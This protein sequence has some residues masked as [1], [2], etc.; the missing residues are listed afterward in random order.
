MPGSVAVLGASSLLAR[1]YVRQEA[2]ADTVELHLFVRDVDAMRGW[3]VQNGLAGRYRVAALDAFGSE[4]H[5]AVVNFIGVGDPARAIALG[6]AIFALTRRWDDRVLAYLERV[7]GARYVFLSSGAVYGDLFERPATTAT[8]AV[9]PINAVSPQHWY[10]LAKL[11]A[12]AVHRASVALSIIDLR[13]FN[14]VSRHTDPAARFLLSDAVRAIGRDAVMDT[15]PVPIV[16][17]YL[18]PADLHALLAACIGAPAGFNG[19]ADAFSRA[20][21]GKDALLRLLGDS[22]GLRYRYVGDADVANATGTKLQYHSLDRTAQR[23][24]YAPTLDSAEGIATEVAA[25]IE[26]QR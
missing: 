21:I 23:W 10:A 16:R 4:D 2:R 25:M 1:D 11:G 9:F 17:D 26:D 5:A 7:P 15:S 19:P 22:F 20:P 14:Y 13:I 24:G 12:E 18:C 8:P 6:A 3:L